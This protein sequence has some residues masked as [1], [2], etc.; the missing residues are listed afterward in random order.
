MRR[1]RHSSPP[2]GIRQADVAEAIVAAARKRPDRP[3][4][5]VLMGREGLPAGRAELRAAG[6]PAYI[7]PESATRA[8]GAMFRYSRWVERPVQAPVRFPT[9]SGR[10]REILDQAHSEGR[11]RLIEPEAYE[12]LSCYGIPV[13][14]HRWARSADEAVDAFEAFGREPVV[15]KAVSPQVV[16][17]TELGGVLLDLRDASAVRDGWDRLDKAVAEHAPEAEFLGA[18]VSPFRS[19]GR[20]MVLGV[21]LDPTFGPLLMFGLGGIYVETFNDVAFRIPP[22]TEFEAHEMI[23]EIRSFPLLAG[24]RGEQPVSLDA[25]A[26]AIQRLSQL[27]LDHDRIGSLDMNPFLAGPEGGMALDAH[28]EIVEPGR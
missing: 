28:I 19:S 6:I 9:D 16:H 18:L 24:V 27:V 8:L 15:M 7:F 5:A 26:E 25:V 21:S 13:I 4:L 23:R 14:P 22:V 3:T 20:E 11:S 2:L 12:V 1:S 10:V 17:K